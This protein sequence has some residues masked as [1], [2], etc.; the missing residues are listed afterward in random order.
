[1]SNQFSGGVDAMT[2]VKLTFSLATVSAA[3]PASRAILAWR[4]SDA[5]FLRRKN[6][7]R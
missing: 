7:L 2:L 3:I 4:G 6:P 1:M 5:T